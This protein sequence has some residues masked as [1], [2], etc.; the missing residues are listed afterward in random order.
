MKCISKEINSTKLHIGKNGEKRNTKRKVFCIPP[1]ACKN[2]AGC[3]RSFEIT[4]SGYD[5]RCE[6]IDAKIHTKRKDLN[7]MQIHNGSL[8]KVNIF[9]RTKIDAHNRM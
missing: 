3:I 4:K 9:G 6:Y 7:G 2:N 8:S 1:M 5:E